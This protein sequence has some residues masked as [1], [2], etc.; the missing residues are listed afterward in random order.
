MVSFLNSINTELDNL[1]RLDN[2][3]NSDPVIPK[4]SVITSRKLNNKT[5]YYQII[6]S[7]NERQQVYLGDSKSIKLRALARSS[8]KR[9]LMRMVKLNIKVLKKALDDY[10]SYSRDDVMARL[11]PC[12]RTV[13]FDA[14][15]DAVMEDLKAWARA[16]YKKNPRPFQGPEIYAKDGT[17][18][19]SK[20]ECIIYNALLMPGSRSAT[21]LC[22]NS[23]G[24]THT[25]NMK[26][27]MIRPI[28]RSSVLTD[29]T[30]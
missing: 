20:S 25:V 27:L 3:L 11:S 15:F 6:S 17:R 7:H 14:D 1:I 18:M 2:D 5:Y 19:R 8:Y 23:E 26:C 16:D 9:E 21:I 28:F 13:Q 10:C 22:L 4:R 30:Y 29:H 12:L 24:K